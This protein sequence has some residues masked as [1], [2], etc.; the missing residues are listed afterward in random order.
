M[1]S[2][3]MS[4]GIYFYIVESLTPESLGKKAKGTFYIIR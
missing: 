3:E 4:T 1:S 2:L